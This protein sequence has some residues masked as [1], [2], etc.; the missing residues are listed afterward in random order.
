MKAGMPAEAFSY[1]P[2][3]TMP[4]PARSCAGP[5]GACS[6]AT[7]SAVGAW[8]GDP[9]VELHGPGYS[10]V[11]IGDDRLGDAGASTST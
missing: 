9:R 4:A 1:F 11:L 5:A 8:E 6:S 10:K 7:S 2:R 3:A